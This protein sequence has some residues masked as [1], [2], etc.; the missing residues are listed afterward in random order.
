MCTRQPFFVVCH[1]SG[2]DF[3]QPQTRHKER[4]DLGHKLDA[5]VRYVSSFRLPGLAQYPI[6]L[7]KLWIV[8]WQ[9]YDLGFV[10]EWPQGTLDRPE[11]AA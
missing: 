6:R 7:A 9:K 10:S 1:S 3:L 5:D 4:S 2:R 11:L 8:L